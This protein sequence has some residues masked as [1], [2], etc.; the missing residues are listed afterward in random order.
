MTTAPICSS[1]LDEPGPAGA[2]VRDVVVQHVRGNGES[3]MQF[4]FVVTCVEAVETV[5]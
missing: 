5:E 1:W 2:R 3:L 4:G